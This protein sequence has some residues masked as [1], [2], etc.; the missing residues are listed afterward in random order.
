MSASREDAGEAWISERLHVGCAIFYGEEGVFRAI[1]TVHDLAARYPLLEVS[2][3]PWRFGQ[4]SLELRAR[5]VT[6]SEF[7]QTDV[8]MIPASQRLRDAIVN[9]RLVLPPDSAFADTPR[10]RCNAHSRPRPA[11]RPT[12]SHQPDRLDRPLTIA[13]ER[14]ENRPAAAR[15][16]GWI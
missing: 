6:S 3:D 14:V 16:I 11:T 7:A 4:A 1:D 13:L 12:R 15:L 9:Q 5:G 10:T 8:R 2:S